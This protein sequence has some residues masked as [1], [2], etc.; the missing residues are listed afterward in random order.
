MNDG[1]EEER[2]IEEKQRIGE[3]IKGKQKKYGQLKQTDW[4]RVE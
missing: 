1:E 4:S 3:I 2:E